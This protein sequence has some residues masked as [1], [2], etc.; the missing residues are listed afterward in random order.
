MAPKT[1]FVRFSSFA[2]LWFLVL[3]SIYQVTVSYLAHGTLSSTQTPAPNDA[4][5]VSL[6]DSDPGHVLHDLSKRAPPE[7]AADA[8]EKAKG[9][10]CKLESWDTEEGSSLHSKYADPT[11]LGKYWLP[12]S[13][14]LKD[15]LT[16]TG[17][18][19]PDALAAIGL[20][21]KQGDRGLQAY[22]YEQDQDFDIDGV[23]EE[24]STHGHLIQCSLSGGQVRD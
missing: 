9:Y 14:P 12:K 18:I 10:M 20:P 7:T 23:L 4:N 8:L 15:G 13:W 5:I 2:F 3:L 16:D 19:I 24:V 6:G 11:D 17:A 21:G 22:Y 1:R